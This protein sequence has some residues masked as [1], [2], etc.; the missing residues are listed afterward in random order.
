MWPEPDGAISNADRQH[1]ALHYSGIS[2]TATQTL[3]PSLFTNTNTFYAAT[4]TPGAVT[5]LPPHYDDADTF[6]SATVAQAG[7]S[8]PL[9]A[10]RLIN[11]SRFYVHILLTESPVPEYAANISMRSGFRVDPRYLVREWRTGLMVPIDEMDEPHPQDFVRG[12]PERVRANPRPEPADTF[13]T[14]N[15]ITA[16]DL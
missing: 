16:A 5:I 13:L 3:T 7:A 9:V 11:E 6:Y 8:A 12:I 15:Q 1:L 14:A 4:V 2:A 10:D